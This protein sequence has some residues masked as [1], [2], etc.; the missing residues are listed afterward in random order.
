M[1]CPRFVVAVF[2]LA[3]CTS[4]FADLDG[5]KKALETVKKNIADDNTAGIDSD[6]KMVDFELK[7]VPD[8]DKK[9]IQTELDGI[10]KKLFDAKVAKLKPGYK[11]SIEHYFEDVKRDLADSHPDGAVDTS[12]R[13]DEYLT[14]DDI[15]EFFSTDEIKA[16]KDRMA[17]YKQMG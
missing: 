2:A 5:A 8:A 15:V 3:L 12:N 16:Y 14:H 6:V 13:L 11:D 9:A 4:V 7:D 17:K 1:T 10:K